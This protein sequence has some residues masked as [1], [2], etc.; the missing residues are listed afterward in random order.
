MI[1]G[2]RLSRVIHYI[3]ALRLKFPDE[4]ILISKYDFSDA[5][6]RVAHSAT[7]AAQSVIVFANITYIEFRLSFG[8]YIHPT[9]LV[10]TFGNDHRFEQRNSTQRELGSK[11][12]IQPDKAVTAKS[13]AQ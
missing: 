8:R 11:R 10:L 6:R 4:R 2:W 7:A 13:K 5:Y 9:F 1:Y 3:I 12:H